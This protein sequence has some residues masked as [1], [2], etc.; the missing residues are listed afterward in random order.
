MNPLE[1]LKIVLCIFIASVE[2]C[3]IFKAM[4]WVCGSESFIGGVFAMAWLISMVFILNCT[5]T[6]MGMLN[7]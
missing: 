5:L 1:I 6:F 2:I 7:G 3:I 4:D